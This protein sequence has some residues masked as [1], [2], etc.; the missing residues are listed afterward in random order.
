[1]LLEV[2]LQG[3]Y[4]KCIIIDSKLYSIET[5]AQHRT[6]MKMFRTNGLHF[7]VYDQIFYVQTL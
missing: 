7:Q 1:M 3:I 2:Q 6:G 5:T 4:G